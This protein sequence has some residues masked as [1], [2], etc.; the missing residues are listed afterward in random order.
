NGSVVSA[1]IVDPLTPATLYVACSNEFGVSGGG[2]YKSTDGGD[3]WNLRTTGMTNTDVRSLAIDP[4]TPTKLYAGVNFGPVFRTTDG[5][6]NWTPSTSGA[7]FSTVSLAVDPHTPARIFASETNSIGGVFR[8]IDS[9]VTWQPVGLAQTGAFSNF[10]GVSPHT[11]NL[12]YATM[13][14]NGLFKSIDGGDNWTSVRPQSRFGNV[15]FDP[16]SSST[17]YFV[18]RFEGVLKS[19]D[20][21]QTWIPMNNGLPT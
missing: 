21:G 15:V 9:G 11:P 5:A 8:S 1:L 20:S 17:L 3:H 14:G 7:P 10:V 2:I 4:V 16:V 12:V 19:T 13:T 18:S 6:D